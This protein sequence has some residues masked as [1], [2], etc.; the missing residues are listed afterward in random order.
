MVT[1]CSL[2]ANDESAAVHQPTYR[3]M[4]GSLLYL[5]GTRPDIMH[6]MG[7]VGRFQANPKE[8]HLH[9]VKRIFKYLQGTEN[10]GL[11]YPEI[12]ISHFMLIGEL[13][14]CSNNAT[15]PGASYLSFY[16]P[17]SSYKLGSDGVVCTSTSSC[18]SCHLVS[19][20]KSARSQANFYR[21]SEEAC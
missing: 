16:Q 10:Y 19:W 9:A 8:T 4:I 11:W 6:A 21:L 18:R 7:M 3:S 13:Q 5:T 1:G 15:T 14:Y 2:S 20:H 17:G 12:Q